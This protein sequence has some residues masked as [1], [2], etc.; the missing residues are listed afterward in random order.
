M[1]HIAIIGAGASG[2]VAAI[3]AARQ[4]VRVTLFEKNN[5]IGRKI[6]ATG[7]GRCN[8]T[9][10]YIETRRFHGGKPSF[11]NGAINRFDA[12]RC[13]QFFRELGI[14]F[15]EGNDGR[16]YPMSL[17]SSSVTEMLGFE[18]E[19]LGVKIL[20]EREVLHVKKKN[21]VFALEV[22]GSVLF[23]DQ[24]LIAT[25]GLAMPTLG[26]CDSGYKI[27][28]AFGHT[29]VT[30]FASLVQLVTKESFVGEVSGVK[31]DGEVSLHVDKELVQQVRG[32]VLFTNYGI[33]GSAILDISRKAGAATL[34]NKEAQ[35]R[36]DLLPEFSKENLRNMLRTR[37]KFSYGKPV[38]VWLDGLI[39][40]KLAELIVRQCAFPK[41]IKS[42]D[43]LTQKEL[44]RLIFA[45]KEMRLHVQ[46]TKG[47]KS[48]ETTAGG[49]DVRE[50]NPETMESKKIIG[51]YF[52]G[53]VLDIDGDCGG[54]NLH[55]AWASGYVAGKAMAT[56]HFSS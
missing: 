30:P 42:A 24:V 20:L 18:C 50:I 33:S 25:G 51:L 47:F 23:F 3:T 7:N 22:D 56:R 29:L 39:N 1:S 13:E 17:Q 40:K 36:V 32:D 35:L 5:K 41:S 37:L 46:E 16:L 4:G 53:E 11:V 49:V 34:S 10:R 14:E 55:W 52:T 44:G 43:D 15:T 28:E 54:F 27:A 6:L 45:L 31:V 38:A 8:I 12:R 48:A 19:R 2:L 9:N 21:D 26:S